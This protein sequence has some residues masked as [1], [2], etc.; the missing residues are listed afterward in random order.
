[1]AKELGMQ[2]IA[3]GVETIEQVNKLSGMGCDC[4]QG[5]FFA[6]PMPLREFDEF[7]RKLLKT[8][9]IPSAVYPTFEDTDNDLLP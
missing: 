6:K 1:M 7:H 8:N 2:V 5:F 3:E 9:Y 4:A